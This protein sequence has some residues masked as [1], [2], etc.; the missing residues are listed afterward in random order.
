MGMSGVRHS[1]LLGGAQL[2]LAGFILFSAAVAYEMSGALS[3]VLAA[4]GA[5]LGLGAIGLL[6]GREGALRVSRVANGLLLAIVLT[7]LTVVLVLDRSYPWNP[8]PR[9]PAAGI[10]LVYGAPP[11]ALLAAFGLLRGRPA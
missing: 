10:F 2:L 5:L 8:A 7:A 6:R 1:G 4:D 11:L 9:G 3:L